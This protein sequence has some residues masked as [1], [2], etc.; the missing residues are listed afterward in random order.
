M[1]MDLTKKEYAAVI[2]ETHKYSQTM[3]IHYLIFLQSHSLYDHTIPPHPS[4]VNAII[5][6]IQQLY[7]TALEFVNAIITQLTY[8]SAI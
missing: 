3:Q 5:T 6:L 4:L 8:S 1:N 2:K 7:S